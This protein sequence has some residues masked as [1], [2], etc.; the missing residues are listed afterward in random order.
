MLVTASTKPNNIVFVGIA[1]G[2]GSGKTYLAHALKNLLPNC[3]IIY[4]DNF[5]RDQSAKFDHDGGAV[6]FDHPDA[7]DF[8]LLLQ[9]LE[10]ISSGRSIEIP[11]YDFAVHKRKSL[12]PVPKAHVYVIDGIL[13]FH[14]ENLRNKFD[15]KI[16]V[17]TPESLRFSRRLDRDIRERGRTP[18]GVREQFLKQVKPMHDQF[19]EPSKKYA[20]E[21]I[22]EGENTMDFL[23]K[24]AEIISRRIV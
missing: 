22:C 2:S 18:E 4:Q 13:I 21:T 16:F 19:V 14:E 20:D 6:N 17:D 1:G 23:Q 5:Y 24:M 10:L 11:V 15:I 7:I 9:S 12:I 8:P 3:E